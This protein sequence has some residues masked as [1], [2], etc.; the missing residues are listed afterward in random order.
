[1]R[2]AARKRERGAVKGPN[3]SPIDPAQAE[4]VGRRF[5]IALTR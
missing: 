1:V 5:G 3:F 4:A 2:T